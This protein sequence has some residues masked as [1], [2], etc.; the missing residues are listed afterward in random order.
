MHAEPLRS[1]EFDIRAADEY[2]AGISAEER[3]AWAL[4]NLPGAHVLSSSF[5]IQAAVS[6][7]L[8]ARHQAD[9]PIIFIDTGYLFPETYRFADELTDHLG[10][11]LK[12]YQAGLS[13]AWI[14]ARHGKLWEE[15]KSGLDQYNRLTKVGPMERALDELQ[16]GTWF[17]G[18]RREQAGSRTDTP[19]IR[20][21][22]GRYKVYPLADWSNK[23][24]WGYMKEHQLPCHPLWEQGYVSV[25]DIHTTRRWEPGMK[26]E[27]TRFFGLQRECG[28]HTEL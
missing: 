16:A 27:D 19:Y 6:L 2:L 23:D 11:N 8:L 20:Y 28:L 18:I 9:I 10:L 13:P 21:N 1:D 26:E 12:V 5:G 22:N 17:S 14:E 4:E 24:I 3:V 15:G 25:G 7:H